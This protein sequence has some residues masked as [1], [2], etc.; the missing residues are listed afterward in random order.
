[1]WQ[2]LKALFRGSQP[3]QALPEAAGVVSAAQYEPLIFLDSNNLHWARLY[4]DFAEKHNLPPFS[5]AQMETADDTLKQHLAGRTLKDYIKGR[6]L[7]GYL[8]KRCNEDAARVEYSPMTILEITC[9]LLRGN[10][11]RE[12]AGQGVTNRMWAKMDELEVL[13]RL[14]PNVYHEIQQHASDVAVQFQKVG[15]TL[16]TTSTDRLREAWSLAQSLLGHVYLEVGD[17]LVVA[18]ALLAEADEIRSG[19]KYVR[20]VVNRIQNADGL[21]EPEKAHYKVV[22]AEIK[23]AVAAIIG[24]GETDIGLPKAPEGFQ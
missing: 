19:D 17:A 21:V 24:V 8:R 3:M 9:G 18:S 6:K 12:A 16:E 22:Q 4:I 23:K 14:Q 5:A 13:E 7:V 20:D 1:M 2:R 10:A 11:I 15:I